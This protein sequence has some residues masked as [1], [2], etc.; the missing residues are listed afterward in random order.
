MNTG[1]MLKAHNSSYKIKVNL[2]SV[3][4][5][6]LSAV[7]RVVSASVFVMVCKKKKKKKR[8]RAQLGWGG[9]PRTHIS[10]PSAHSAKAPALLWDQ[11]L[12]CRCARMLTALPAPRFAPK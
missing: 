7:L 3:L 9:L 6:V 8:G 4:A 1:R 11:P 5:F 12:A 10:I 2:V